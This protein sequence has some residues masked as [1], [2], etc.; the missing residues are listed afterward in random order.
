[1]NILLY[2]KVLKKKIDKILNCLI[3][4]DHFH[5]IK[6]TEKEISEQIKSANASVKIVLYFS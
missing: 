6:T 3:L 5:N 1:M 2:Q 4:I